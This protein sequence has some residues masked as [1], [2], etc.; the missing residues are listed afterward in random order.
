M[1]TN[2]PPVLH[3]A[4]GSP[5]QL[6]TIDIATPPFVPEDRT[7]PTS[8]AIRLLAKSIREHGVIQP[9]IVR[10]VPPTWVAV[11]GSYNHRREWYAVDAS[12]FVAQTYAGDLSRYSYASEREATARAVAM[13]RPYQVICGARRLAAAKLAGLSTVPV[14][15]VESAVNAEAMWKASNVTL[16][17]LPT[18]QPSPTNTTAHSHLDTCPA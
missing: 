13:N 15:V 11:A 8:E 17:A 6:P 2:S 14:V 3:A 1:P 18:S 5:L 7:L 9:I 12:A 16:D 4:H 10:S